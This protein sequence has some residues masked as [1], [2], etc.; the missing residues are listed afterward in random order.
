MDA[1]TESSSS[2]STQVPSKSLWKSLGPG[3]ITAAV[4]IGPGTITVASKLGGAAGSSMLWVLLIAGSFMMLFTA[5]SARIGTL[6]NDSLLT[7]VAKHYGRWLAVLIGVMA[8]TV[9]ASFQLSNYLAS[10]TAMHTLTGVSEPVWLFAVGGLGLVFLFAAR[11]LYRALE[12]IMTALVFVMILAFFFNMLVAGPNVLEI[13]AGFIPKSWPGEINGL[14][15]AMVATTFSVIAALYQSTLAQQK[16]WKM[17]DLRLATRESMVGI[18]VLMFVSMVIMIT[19]GSV[20]RGQEIA[21]AADLA[22]QLE[23]LLGRFS[24]LLFSLGFLSAAFSSVIIN[25]MIGGGLLADGLGMNSDI[26]GVPNRIFTAIAMLVGIFAGY[27]SLS[28]GTALEGIVIA[29][30]T[31]ILAVPIVALVMILLANNRKVVGE[32]R[33]SLV[34]NIWAGLAFLVLLRMNYLRLAEI[35]GW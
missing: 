29:Q 21:S 11:H 35:F 17:N 8:F 5:M 13:L 30:K 6:S 34:F 25:A 16:G 22:N 27:Y 28:T 3:L 33:N 14:V 18:G 7:Q 10:A 9:A 31:T 20:L 4:V 24:V 26:N 32:N 23:P 12:K 2:P 15:V 1:T 19:S